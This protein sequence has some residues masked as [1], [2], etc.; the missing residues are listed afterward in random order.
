[1]PRGWGRVCGAGGPESVV[2]IRFTL[3]ECSQKERTRKEEVKTKCSKPQIASD[4]TSWSPN[5]KNL[6]Q[7]T[8]S[9]SSF[10]TFKSRDL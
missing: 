2:K 5:R 10:R 7:I 1:M 4:L 9:D 3:A 8:V 6:P